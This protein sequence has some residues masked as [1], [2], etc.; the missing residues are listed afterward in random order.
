MRKLIV[1][2]ALAAALVAAG[3]ALRAE[4]EQ[5]SPGSM[6]GRGMMGQGRSM[7]GQTSRMMDHCGSMMQGRGDSGNRPNDQWRRRPP[8]APDDNG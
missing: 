7:M 1:T 3:T 5:G 4:D 6:M 2:V 8:S